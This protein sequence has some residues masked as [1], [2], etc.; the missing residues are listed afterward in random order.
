MLLLLM[1]LL[2]VMLLSREEKCRHGGNNGRL[3]TIGSRQLVESKEAVAA[4]AVCWAAVAVGPADL[5]G[6]NGWGS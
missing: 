2:S 5:D 3:A 4:G 6:T 1:E